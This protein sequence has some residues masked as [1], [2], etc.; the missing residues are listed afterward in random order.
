MT[1][2][3]IDRLR[4]TIPTANL[5]FAERSATV[6]V[7]SGDR[8]GRL[9][10]CA[11]QPDAIELLEDAAGVTVTEGHFLTA[12]DQESNV[13]PIVITEEVSETLFDSGRAIG[14]VI[15]VGTQEFTIVGVLR[16]SRDTTISGARHDAYIPLRSFNTES[17]GGADSGGIVDRIWIKVVTIDNVARTR[18][19]CHEVIWQRLTPARC[20]Q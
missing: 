14:E 18:E 2:R 10:I 17:H 1:L 13:D 20:S 3:D 11:T 19:V 9:S 5:L 7:V 15:K 4:A 16:K 8:T 12:K 6:D